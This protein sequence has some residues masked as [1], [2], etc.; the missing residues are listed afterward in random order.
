MPI[1][2]APM[3][4]INALVDH[5]REKFGITVH[6]LEPMTL[7]ASDVNMNRRQLVAE[8]VIQSML[9]NYPKYA[10]NKSAILIGI[11]AYDMYP[12]GENWQFCFGWRITAVRAAVVSTARMELEYP[13]EPVIEA[14]LQK[15]LRKV[16][17]KDI[18]IMYY[19]KSPNDNPKS[20]L[21]NGILGI[22][23]LDQV[24]EDF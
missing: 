20:V 9:R 23:E 11:T 3:P 4:E 2:D 13:D 21:F 24:T 14:T 17:T 10:S 6:V 19:G 1:G 16:V 7:D 15:R 8:N 18:G 5:Y 12:R 22:Q